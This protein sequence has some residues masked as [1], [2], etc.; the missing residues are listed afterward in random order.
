MDLPPLLRTK[1][2]IP[3]LRPELVSRLHLLEKLD[4][5]LNTR[6]T[7]I[8]SPAGFGKTTLLSEWVQKTTLPVGWITLDKDDND[9]PRFLAYLI[10]ALQKINPEVEPDA[11]ELLHA[12]QPPSVQAVLTVLLNQIDQIPED[13]LL[14]LDDYHL[15]EQAVIHQAVEILINHMPPQMHLVIVSRADPPIQLARLRGQ[16]QLV[17]LRLQ[18][19]RFS[20]EDCTR[21]FSKSL[22]MNLSDTDLQRL[23]ARTEG[24]ITGLQMAALSL[25]GRPDVRAFIE[26][27]SGSHRYILDYLIE[28][29]LE[30][31]SDE[32]RSFLFQTSILD[33]FTGDLCNAV[34]KRDDAEEILAFLERSNLF[35][36]PL[37]EH[38]QWYRYHRLFADLLQARLRENHPAEFP[39][40]HERASRWHQKNGFLSSAVDHALA[41]GQHGK[42][43]ELIGEIAEK[44]LMRSETATLLAWKEKL[45]PAALAENPNLVFVFLWANAIAAYQF[46]TIQETLIRL[47]AGGGLLPGRAETLLAFI[48]ISKFEMAAAEQ[49]AR[50]ALTE[51]GTEDIYF[52]SFALW[53]YGLTQALKNEYQEAILVMEE[54]F[55]VSRDHENL[56]FS[57]LTACQMARLQ[58]H[59]GRLDKAEKIYQQA[60][61]A[62]KNRRG[63]YLPI[64]GEALMGLGDLYREQNL[65][66]QA[67]DHIIEGIELTKMWRDVAALEGYLYLARVKRAQADWPAAQDALDKAWDLAIKYDATDIDDRMVALEQARLWLAAGDLPAVEAW[68]A[69]LPVQDPTDLGALADQ[70][71]V[72]YQFKTRES[73]ILTRLCIK[74][75]QY[76]E[77]LAWID[78]QLKALESLGRKEIQVETHLLQAETHQSAGDTR[79][80]LAALEQALAIAEPSG[81]IRIVLDQGPP[82]QK[83]LEKVK[84]TTYINKLLSQFQPAG[85]QPVAPPQSLIDPLSERELEILRLLPT[86]LTTP[87]MAAELYISVSTVR[88]HIKSIYSKLNVHRRTEAVN[89]AEDL[90]LL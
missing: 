82:I 13:F 58:M 1:L 40:L 56:M 21:F 9:F 33:R 48:A 78:H 20:A 74:Q 53:I 38:R 42:A 51:L 37:D 55:K 66:D 29:V 36:V 25:R 2:H 5:G 60:L 23:L 81:Y 22:D 17:E 6:L 63:R 85:R 12:P 7:L 71:T 26:S 68:A 54:L 31:Q 83:L 73:L 30:L 88:S 47:S 52:R 3:R 76:A 11:L 50:K 15:I 72:E 64:S 19:L 80:A 57:M 18:D 32:V 39:T 49:Q 65:L 34:T 14:V 84:R 59:L 75:G 10:A 4:D 28:E 46:D 35:I 45:P 41:A 44:K 43:V 77:A 27:F 62:G 87:E 61:A 90:G 8:S 24:W 16:G 89:Q 69:R 67:T 79:K 86:N 70:G